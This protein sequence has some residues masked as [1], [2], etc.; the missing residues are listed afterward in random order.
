MCILCFSW[1]VAEP[2][3]GSQPV[4]KTW[5]THGRIVSSIRWVLVFRKGV[6]GFFLWRVATWIRE[7][8]S[9]LTSRQ[10]DKRQNRS[11]SIRWAF[12]GLKA[13]LVLALP[14]MEFRRS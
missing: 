7:K 10:Y 12:I 4:S 8:F 2:W 9:S 11:L 13:V 1:T 14:L 3:I 6:D 5:I